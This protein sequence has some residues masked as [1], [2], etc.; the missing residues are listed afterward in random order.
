MIFDLASKAD[1]KISDPK[2]NNNG[3]W[4]LLSLSLIDFRYPLSNQG[5]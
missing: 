4:Y 5:K 3:I 2:Q 1:W